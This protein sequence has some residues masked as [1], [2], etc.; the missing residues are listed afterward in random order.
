MPADDDGQISGVKISVCKDSHQQRAGMWIGNLCTRRLDGSPAAG[1][2]GPYEGRTRNSYTVSSP[3]PRNRDRL[4]SRWRE[5]SAR[6]RR[7]PLPLLDG[8]LS[9]L[10]DRAEAVGRCE[11]SDYPLFVTRR[12]LDTAHDTAANRSTKKPVPCCW[13]IFIGSRNRSRRSSAL[14]TMPSRRGTRIKPSFAWTSRQMA[15]P[16]CRPSCACV[17]PGSGRTHELALG[18]AHAHNFLPSVLANGQPQCPDCPKR[19]PAS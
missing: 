1:Q 5:L 19:T 4:R 2:A 6:V 9:D 11:T 10:L 15:S 18:F 12:A 14:L 7:N 8:Q 16:T 13:G 3:G 17:N